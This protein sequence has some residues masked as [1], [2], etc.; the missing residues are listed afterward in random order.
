MSLKVC[1]LP[2]STLPFSF[3][4]EQ[5][6]PKANGWVKARWVSA[7]G[8]GLVAQSM[9]WSPGQVRRCRGLRG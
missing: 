1:M 2:C 4:L 7:V 9:C 3:L 8:M 5:V 6:S